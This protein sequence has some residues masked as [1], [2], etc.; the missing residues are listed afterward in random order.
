MLGVLWG[1]LFFRFEIR[2]FRSAHYDVCINGVLKRSHRS[3]PV[4]SCE[5]V[6]QA[7]SPTKVIFLPCAYRCDER[8]IPVFVNRRMVVT[9]SNSGA[10]KQVRQETRNPIFE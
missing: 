9:K 2:V 10:L 4:L 7:D 5:N 1:V 6:R 8:T 3:E